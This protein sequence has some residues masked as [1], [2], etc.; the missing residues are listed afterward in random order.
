MSRSTEHSPRTG[1]FILA[2]LGAALAFAACSTLEMPTPIH[3]AR[4]TNL[5]APTFEHH[6]PALDAGT[7]DS[8]GPTLDAAPASSPAQP[9]GADAGHATPTP[10]GTP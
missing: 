10:V 5:V 6:P 8:P 1:G 3:P 4:T 7:P 2:V 9:Q